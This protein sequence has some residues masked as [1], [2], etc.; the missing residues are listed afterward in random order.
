[1]TIHGEQ[2][3]LTA[4]V[5][6]YE[7]VLSLLIFVFILVWGSNTSLC[8][9]CPIVGGAIGGAVAG[10]FTFLSLFFMKA[11]NK[12]WLKLL[13]WFGCFAGAVLV[14]WGVALLLI[15]AA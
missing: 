15:G 3:Q 13:I 12:L 5:K 9:I 2:I 1:M 6:W 11:T 14:C 7:A 4:P 8:A 10:V